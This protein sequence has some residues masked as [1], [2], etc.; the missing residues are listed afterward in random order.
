MALSDTGRPDAIPAERVGHGPPAE[1]IAQRLGLDGA[2]RSGLWLCDPA[3]VERLIAGVRCLDF[4]SPG[5]PRATLLHLHG[6][7]FRIGCPE[8]VGPYA[9][10]LAA[11]CRVRVICPAYRLAPEYPFPAGLG[12]GWGVLSG[13]ATGSGPLIVSGDSAGGGL[14]A[15]LAALFACAGG[16][17]AGLVLFSPWLDLTVTSACYARNAARDPLFSDASA[18]AAAALYLQGVSPDSSLASPLFGPVSGF[19]PSY[20]AVG[21]GEVLQDDSRSMAAK[22]QAEGIDVYLH[23]VEGMDHVAVVRDQTLTG[24]QETFAALTA[25][26]DRILE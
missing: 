9:A 21:T 17:L 2:I 7:G 4:A 10:A 20:I 5:V 13:L 14:A 26:I 3:P 1:L 12:D 18:R 11:R 25:F 8:Q 24:S 6:G 22:L 19:P 16:R 15:G 23:E